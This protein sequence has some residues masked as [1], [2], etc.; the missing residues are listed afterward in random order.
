MIGIIRWYNN[1]KGFGFIQGEDGMDVIVQKSN[2]PKGM[3]LF[4]GEKVRYK[5]KYAY[6]GPQANEV[7]KV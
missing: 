2:L 3:S 4:S 6:R 5:I 7:K 1:L